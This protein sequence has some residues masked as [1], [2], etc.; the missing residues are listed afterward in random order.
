MITSFLTAVVGGVVVL[1]ADRVRWRREDK[2]RWFQERRAAY[3]GYLAAVDRWNELDHEAAMSGELEEWFEVPTTDRL[4]P[5]LGLQTSSRIRPRANAHAAIAHDRL[6]DLALFGSSTVLMN[7]R[8]LH[9][10]MHKLSSVRYGSPPRACGGASQDLIGADE[11]FNAVRRAFVLT[12][13]G[14][15]GAD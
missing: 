7:A 10:E 1:F 14:E 8:L 11:Q 15:L 2:T 12:V 5:L 9:D 6:T 4:D 3:G 13:R